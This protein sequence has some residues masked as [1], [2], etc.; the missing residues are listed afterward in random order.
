MSLSEFKDCVLCTLQFLFTLK[1]K[2]TCK[3]CVLLCAYVW[4][5][6]CVWLCMTVE[7]NSCKSC[8]TRPYIPFL[9]F[10]PSWVFVLL[11]SLLVCVFHCLTQNLLGNHR[12]ILTY[13]VLVKPHPFSLL[14]PMPCLISPLK[15]LGPSLIFILQNHICSIIPSQKGM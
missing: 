8:K 5:Q 3:T 7:A 13:L 6:D 2:I 4:F 9:V 14:L 1:T 10:N 11:C 15:L 12:P